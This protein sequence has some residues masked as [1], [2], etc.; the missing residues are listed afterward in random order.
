MADTVGH[1]LMTV[2]GGY[3]SIDT[4]DQPEIWAV[5]LRLWVGHTEPDP[6]GS[7]AA[8]YSVVEDE[9]TVDDT[10]YTVTSNWRLEGGIN[11]FDPVSYVIDQGRDYVNDWCN[12]VSL[13]AYAQVH[14]IKLFFIGTDGKAVGPAGF[15]SGSPTLLTYKDTHQP[16]G[17]GSSDILPPQIAIVASHRTA[18]TGRRGQ[19]RQYRP[20]VD[21]NSVTAGGRL[22]SAAQAATVASHVAAL[23]S[24]KL[25]IADATVVR[26]AVI[27]N[28]GT[29]AAPDLSRYAVINSVRVGDVLDTQRRRRNKL[30]ETYVETSL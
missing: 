2:T 9:K 15:G 19:G 17:N 24:A 13:S 5:N 18:Q 20:A 7:L 29:A 6:V 12:C 21:Q 3:K 30:V 28:T 16:N 22:S 8:I 26:P 27:T 11:D 23:E 14:T 1:L 4:E 10:D 25:T